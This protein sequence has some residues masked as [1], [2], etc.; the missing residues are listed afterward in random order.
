MQ[1]LE[2]PVTTILTLPY[3]NCSFMQYAK[4]LN[5]DIDS[6]LNNAT[7]NS[8]HYLMTMKAVLAA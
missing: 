6:G 5:T 7:R 1:I 8:Q 2:Y 3:A 4:E